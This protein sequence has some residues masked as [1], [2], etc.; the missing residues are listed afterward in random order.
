M[1]LGYASDGAY[2]SNSWHGHPS[3]SWHHGTGGVAAA[4]AQGTQTFTQGSLAGPA[5]PDLAPPEAVASSQSQQSHASN[6]S[7]SQSPPA[8]A[9]QTTSQQTSPSQ[10]TQQN[11]APKHKPINTQKILAGAKIAVQ[12]V[13]LLGA[14]AGLASAL[15]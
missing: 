12:G 11:A 13:K 8:P 4:S 7:H 9:N 10:D 3:T 2:Q 5:P 6:T 14:V 15:S 1:D